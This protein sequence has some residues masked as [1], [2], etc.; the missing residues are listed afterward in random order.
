MAQAK[1]ADL[2]PFFAKVPQHTN[3]CYE[4]DDILADLLKGEQVLWVAWDND[5]KRVDAVMTTRLAEFPRRKICEVIFVYGSRM[6]T[7]LTEFVTT[8]EQYAQE[9]GA[10]GLAGSFRR[11]WLRVW[12]GCRE[13]GTVLFK[14]LV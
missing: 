7:W 2:A 14:D 9:Q 3:G 10:T 6:A 4:P 1:W 8:V 11:G 12:P 13:H 5:Q